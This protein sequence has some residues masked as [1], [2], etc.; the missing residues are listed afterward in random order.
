MTPN[1]LTLYW[2]VKRGG[3]RS[4][5]QIVSGFSAGGTASFPR[6]NFIFV[7]EKDEVVE[8]FEMDPSTSVYFHDPYYVP[9]D[10]EQTEENLSVLDKSQRR[11]YDRL[12]QTVEFH[13]IYKNT[14][15]RSYLGNYLRARPRVFMW[16]ADYFGQEH[17]ATSKETHFTQL[18]PKEA[19]TNDIVSTPAMHTPILPEYRN[20]S[21]HPFLNMTLRVLSCAPRV[22]E[23]NNFLSQVEV[24]HLHEMSGTVKFQRSSTGGS[25]TAA[26][27]DHDTKTRTSFNSWMYREHSPIVD[28][29]YRRAADLER[30]DE[31]LMRKRGA[32]E[33][34]DVQFKKSYA[35][36]LQLGMYE[37]VLFCIIL[38]SR[39]MAQYDLIVSLPTWGVSALCCR[40]R[41]Y[42]VRILMSCC[43]SYGRRPVLVLTLPLPLS[44]H[45]DF[46][47][48]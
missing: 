6:H 18:P 42:K 38:H 21:E 16:P 4:L 22:F 45:H 12:R 3:K 36:A 26:D 27:D 41:I 25:N 44:S 8:S 37:R 20:A 35:E 40:S 19:L 7:N 17:W 10:D 13:V 14:T 47:Y 15:G 33:R 2:E 11:Q 23:I 28:A 48:S 5:I 9:G 29:I 24:D 32:D 1:K 43:T 46:G 39:L 30:I 34:P 31:A